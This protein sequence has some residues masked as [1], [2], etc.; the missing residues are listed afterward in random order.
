ML[1]MD[2]LPFKNATVLI[3]NTLNGIGN[4]YNDFFYPLLIV[5]GYSVMIFMLAIIIYK[6]KMKKA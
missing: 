4:I 1:V 6:G 2:Y 5:I 3:Q